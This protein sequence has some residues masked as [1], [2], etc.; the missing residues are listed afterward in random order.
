MLNQNQ[1]DH[2]QLQ[3]PTQQGFSSKVFIYSFVKDKRADAGLELDIIVCGQERHVVS[4]NEIFVYHEIIT[5]IDQPIKIEQSE[6]LSF[7]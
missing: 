1:T 2:T 5:E 7:F 3:I 6:I 4:T